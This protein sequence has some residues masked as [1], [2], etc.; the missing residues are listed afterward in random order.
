M[1]NWSD[2]WG[3]KWGCREEALQ[4]VSLA[5]ICTRYIWWQ[6]RDHPNINT[7][8][9]IF[10][11]IFSAIDVK[12]QNVAFNRGIDRST[13]GELDNWGAM[14]GEARN[15]ASD[16][17]YRAVIKAKARASIGSGNISDFHDV[18]TL[19]SPE[20]N[21]RFLERYPA[22]VRMF[23]SDAI[24]DQQ[25]S[26]M[27]TL[28]R[29]VPGLGICIAFVEVDD[30]GVFEFS[31]L[32]EDLSKDPVDNHWGHSDGDIADAAGFAYLIE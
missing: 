25:R 15:G 1:T 26:I 20:S 11:I 10:A 17:L 16:P 8:C 7:L 22:C 24:S 13:G 23:F 9:A 28:M 18:A 12:L 2:K 3:G 31:Y 29:Q 32:N 6:H 5:D 30:D 4:R 14:V 27:L 21:P 19:I